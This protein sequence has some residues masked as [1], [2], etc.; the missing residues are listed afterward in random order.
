MR[1]DK[2]RGESDKTFNRHET[3]RG[4]GER[5]RCESETGK[6]GGSERAGNSRHKHSIL[7]GYKLS[8]TCYYIRLQGISPVVFITEV[9]SQDEMECHVL[10]SSD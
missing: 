10:S 2:T 7:S 9:H 1:V 3:E 5:G 4:A 6:R 8:I